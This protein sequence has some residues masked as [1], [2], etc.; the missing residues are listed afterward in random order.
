MNEKEKE[1][2]IEGWKNIVGTVLYFFTKLK[3]EGK[4][5]MIDGE[6]TKA[7]VDRFVEHIAIEIAKIAENEID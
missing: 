6:H 4:L 2:V 3:N 1:R 7:T 5:D